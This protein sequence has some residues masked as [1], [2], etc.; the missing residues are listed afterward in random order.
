MCSSPL[1]ARAPSDRVLH[2]R[3]RHKRPA[4]LLW[5]LIAAASISSATSQGQPQQG[6]LP[7]AEAVVAQYVASLRTGDLVQLGNLAGTELRTERSRLIRDPGYSSFLASIFADA[8]VEILDQQSLAPGSVVTTIEIRYG[9]GEW[10]RERLFLSRD[11]ESSVVQ[12][13][14]IEPLP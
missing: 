1:A 8:D 13:V 3:R 4:F 9:D 7:W 6:Y 10:I 11:Q 12:I 2:G 14:H 5:A